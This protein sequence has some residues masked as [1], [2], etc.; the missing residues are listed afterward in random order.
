MEDEGDTTLI[1]LTSN[2]FAFTGDVRVRLRDQHK[3]ALIAATNDN[4]LP[5]LEDMATRTE[6]IRAQKLMFVPFP[7]MHLLLEKNLSPCHTFLEIYTFLESNKVLAQFSPLL[8]SLCI[9]STADSTGEPNSQ[10]LT[11]GSMFLA[12]KKLV[13]FMKERVLY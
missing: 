1:K 10:H 4:L 9:A 5:A 6:I 11:P 8:I 7:V 12:D 13:S 3:A 2:M